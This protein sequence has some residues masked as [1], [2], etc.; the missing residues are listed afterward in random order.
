M[1]Q[2]FCYEDTC[3]YDW[4][5]A[6]KPAKRRV[7]K[8]TLRSAMAMASKSGVAV[9]GAVVKADGSVELMFGQAVP[10]DVVSNDKPEKINRWDEVLNRGPAKIALVER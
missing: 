9:S 1:P 7:R 8:P 4:P 6:R 2:P 3:R 5:P 10:V